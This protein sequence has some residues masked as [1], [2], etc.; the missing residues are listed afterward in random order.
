MP[1]VFTGHIVADRAERLDDILRNNPDLDLET[2]LSAYQPGTHGCHEALHA[3]SIFA[4]AVNDQLLS[5]A[6]IVAN[7]AW[8]DMAKSALD[9]LF[10]L[11]HAIGSEHFSAMI[12]GTNSEKSA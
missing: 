8:F 9:S 10:G 2:L 12:S 1:D 6:A 7:P 4:T 5:H 11:Y 3:T